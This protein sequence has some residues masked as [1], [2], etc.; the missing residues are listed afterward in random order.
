[1]AHRPS[2]SPAH[3][4]HRAVGTLSTG[5]PQSRSGEKTRP[6]RGSGKQQ[7]TATPHPWA[8]PGSRPQP[9]ALR[10][11]HRQPILSC[12]QPVLPSACP[13]PQPVPVT[14][15]SL[16]LSLSLA[17]PCPTLSLSLSLPS[18]C[19][20]LQPV[21][22]LSLSLS[23]A[24]PCHCPQPVPI[25]PSACPCLQPVPVFSS[26]LS[27]P[28][29]IPLSAS[30]EATP[31]ACPLDPSSHGPCCAARVTWTSPSQPF[32]AG[33]KVN[34][35]DP[36]GGQQPLSGTR[37]KEMSPPVE[38]MSQMA[39]HL[40]PPQVGPW[41]VGWGRLRQVLPCLPSHR[42]TQKQG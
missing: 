6:S 18:A 26:S 25:L 22:V 1:M 2:Q 19:P 11:A 36:D 31:Q 13:Y 33:R 30:R 40:L 7:H 23:S 41:R 12:P 29:P 14:A 42:K 28:Q 16:S 8:G 3:E 27:C 5:K 35:G 24:C 37:R 32:L 4:T 39:R 34:L 20:Y 15:L 17:C 21:P 38:A 9:P 10:P